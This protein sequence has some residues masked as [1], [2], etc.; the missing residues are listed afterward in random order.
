MSIVAAALP[1]EFTPPGVEEFWQ[2]LIG[3]G[4]WA[5]TRP[6]FLMLFSGVLIVW[7]LHATTK[8]RAR[9]SEAPGLAFLDRCQR[10]VL[11]ATLG[12]AEARRCVL[13]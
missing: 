6:M 12:S 8:R 11:L 3:D 4:A 2:P 5:I 9:R 13:R 7:W 10:L 1:T